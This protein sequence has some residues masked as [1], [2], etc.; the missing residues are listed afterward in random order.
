MSILSIDCQV[1]S[2]IGGRAACVSTITAAIRWPRGGSSQHLAAHL[3][4]L[5][6]SDI[7]AEI[8]PRAHALTW[9]LL[10]KVLLEVLDESKDMTLRI[11]RKLLALLGERIAYSPGS[12]HPVWGPF[13]PG[14]RRQ[15]AGTENL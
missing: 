3:F 8:G 9:A 12:L 7:R 5:F 10:P 13:L 2:C 1:G 6:R 14:E 15:S 11:R 4:N